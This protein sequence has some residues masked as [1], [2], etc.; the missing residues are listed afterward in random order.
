MFKSTV[1]LY[2]SFPDASQAQPSFRHS[3]YDRQSIT[4][5]SAPYPQRTDLLCERA[6]RP[7]AFATLGDFSARN[8]PLIETFALKSVSRNHYSQKVPTNST[9]ARLSLSSPSLPQQFSPE[10]H[11]TSQVPNILSKHDAVT[12]FLFMRQYSHFQFLSK[13]QCRYMQ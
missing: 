12:V 7:L 2:L 4:P 10:F 1:I 6:F 5:C 13:V 3:L 8:S 11:L 9:L